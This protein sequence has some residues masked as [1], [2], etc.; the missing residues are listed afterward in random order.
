MLVTSQRFFEAEADVN[1]RKE[2]V[3]MIN[4]LLIIYAAYIYIYRER[5][6]ERKKRE[7]K[8]DGEREGE[9]EWEKER[10]LHPDTVREKS[11]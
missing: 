7:R 9:R 5:E 11:P 4:E 1:E 8:W 6:R 3:I 10:G 2:E